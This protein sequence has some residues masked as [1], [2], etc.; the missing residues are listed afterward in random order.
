MSVLLN[1]SPFSSHNP[2]HGPDTRVLYHSIFAGTIASPA[3]V[4]RWSDRRFELGLLVTGGVKVISRT[5]VAGV[6]FAFVVV[7]FVLG[8]VKVPRIFGKALAYAW[9]PNT[10]ILSTLRKI[11]RNQLYPLRGASLK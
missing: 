9:Q 7:V 1:V 3:L 5:V 10:S 2:E 11:E 4:G 6:D 8:V